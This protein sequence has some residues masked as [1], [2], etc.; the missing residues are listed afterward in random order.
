MADLKKLERKMNDMIASGQVLEAFEEFVAD[1]VVMQDNDADPTVGKDA[2]RERENEFFSMVEDVHAVELIDSAVGDGVS[3]SEWRYD[4]TFKGGDRVDWV[5]VERRRWNDDDKV[6]H[7][8]FYYDP[9]Y[10]G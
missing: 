6:E 10:E 4:M 1:D 5:Q 3:Y 7:V 2:N 9:P 8:R